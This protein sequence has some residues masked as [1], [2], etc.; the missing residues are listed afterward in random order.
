M[1]S[2]CFWASVVSSLSV[3]SFPAFFSAISDLRRPDFTK[4]V[5]IHFSPSV[6]FLL[7]RF[8]GCGSLRFAWHPWQPMELKTS[9][10]A[11]GEPLR[12][13]GAVCLGRRGSAVRMRYSVMQRASCRVRRSSSSLELFSSM[14]KCGIF[15]VGRN[16]LGAQIHVLMYAGES[17]L[18]T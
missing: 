9:L 5:T 15:V 12:P 8:S 6:T 16:D 14:K 1:P 13:V 17:L 18:V 11:S 7:L 10:P 2:Y 4:S 3:G